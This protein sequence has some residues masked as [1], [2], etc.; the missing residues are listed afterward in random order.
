M[1]NFH[2][3]VMDLNRNLMIS[4]FQESVIIIMYFII[5]LIDL[6][7]TNEMLGVY[8]FSLKKQTWGKMNVCA[9][10][11]WVVVCGRKQY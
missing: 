6:M 9:E 5:Y 2:A 11:M 7:S 3:S 10:F 4:Y 1:Y 8:L